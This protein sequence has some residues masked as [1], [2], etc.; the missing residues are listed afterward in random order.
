VS[1]VDPNLNPVIVAGGGGGASLPTDDPSSLLEDPAS[2]SRF[3]VTNAAG[4]G[5]LATAAEAQA[6]LGLLT[7]APLTS[8]SG[9]TLRAGAGGATI[10]SSVARIT[11]ASGVATGSWSL[12]PAAGYPYALANAAPPHY[13]IDARARVAAWTGGNSADVYASFSIRLGTAAPDALSVSIRGDGGAV[14]G[15]ANVIGSNSTIGSAAIVARGTI[16][17]GQ[18]WVRIVVS[19]AT[20]Y[21]YHGTG[22]AG[23]QPTTWTLLGTSTTMTNITSES[24]ALLM[25]NADGGAGA[26]DA[27]T[28]DW[29]NIS[30]RLVGLP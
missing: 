10:T 14:F 20:I 15:Y 17:G 27:V 7:V 26:P 4:N 3:F 6:L 25:V 30:A 5:A 12:Q 19:G 24:I 2:P 13:A 8:P 16:A 9:W 22:S 28:I 23:A 21:C 18:W 1:A 11:L 29:D